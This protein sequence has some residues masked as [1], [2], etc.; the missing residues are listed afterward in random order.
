VAAVS[1][2]LPKGAV[3][4]STSWL[5]A[6]QNSNGDGA[7]MEPFVVA[8][9]VIGLAM[10]V[11]IVANVVSGAVAAQYRRIGVLKS[12]GMTP[13]QVVTVYLGRIGLPALIGVAAG[14]VLGDVLSV[15]LLADSAG[16]YG[17]GS[18]SAPFWA[19][20]VAP[21][22]MLALTM[23]AAFLPALR[24]GRLSATQAIAAGHAPRTG[25]GYLVHRVTSR[26]RLPR[27]VGIGL[28]QPF[29]R[30]GRTLVTLFAI[31]FG[32]C[33]V[34]FAVGLTAGLGRAEQAQTHAAE[35]PVTIQQNLGQSGGGPAVEGHPVKIAGP[36]R[37]GGGRHQRVGER[38]LGDGL[39]GQ[40]ELE[41][42]VQTSAIRVVE[43]VGRLRVIPR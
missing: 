32:A 39:V 23:L 8:F 16:V 11:L 40:H 4:S 20:I 10:A 28:A 22:G 25:R 34:I 42:G 3:S 43:G 7:I 1:R 26:L 29:A 15:P 33:A 41:V 6:R 30:P 27:P 2:D 35:A 18:Q 14:T 36:G 12:L 38:A 24:A 19:L 9:A 31:A 17:V 13:G 5:T 21:L 37:V